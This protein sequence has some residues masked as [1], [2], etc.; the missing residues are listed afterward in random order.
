VTTVLSIGTTHPW[1]VA[2]VGLDVR[3]GAELDV[4]VLS[5]V[6]AVSAQDA[7]GLHAL[8]AVPAAIVRAELASIAWEEVDAIRVGAIGS[9]EGVYAVAQAAGTT[10][11]PLVVDPVFAATLGGELADEATIRAI[12][13]ALATLPTAIVTPN[14]IEA[15][16]MLGDCVTRENIERSAAALQVRGARAI[17]LKGGHLDGPPIDALATAQ[18]VQLF[19]GD[20]IAGQMRGTGCTLAMALSC[21]LAR[22]E[23]L[24]DAVAFARE[25]V[26]DKI[27]RAVQLGATRAAY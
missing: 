5:V 24:A 3:I 17:L 14:V 16:V 12:R 6:T 23:E 4:R 8:H 27:E 25:F 22:G 2:G 10:A 18:G 1:N 20:R 9:A 21:S 11:A 26:R 15:G 13:D 7:G 19:E